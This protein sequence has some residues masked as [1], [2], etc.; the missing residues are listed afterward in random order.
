[1]RRIQRA[2]LTTTK[3]DPVVKAVQLNK[4][5]A[6]HIELIKNSFM[7][8]WSWW[9]IHVEWNYLP[10]YLDTF[11][12]QQGFHARQQNDIASTIN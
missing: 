11:V 6:L 1:M 5:I 10:K 12:S 7:Q 9:L 4:K 2:S 8:T 3:R